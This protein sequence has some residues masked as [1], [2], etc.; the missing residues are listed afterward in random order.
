MTKPPEQRF[1]KYVD[2]STNLPCWTWFGASSPNGYGRFR[3]GPRNVPMIGPHRFSFEL[4]HGPIPDGHVVMHKC[5]NPACVNP[6]H[7]TSGTNKDNTIDA[8]RKGRMKAMSK[9]GYDP[10][11]PW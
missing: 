11:R 5:D 8:M 4:H 1:W 2:K 7:L 10:R 3:P 9:H 6:E